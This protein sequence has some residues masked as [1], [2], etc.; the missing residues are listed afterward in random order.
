MSERGK[1]LLVVRTEQVLKPEI[2]EKLYQMMSDVAESLGCKA[3]VAD[4]GLDVSVHHDLRPLLQAQLEAQRETNELLTSLVE[5]LADDV[6]GDDEEVP[7]TYMDGTQVA[8]DPG[9]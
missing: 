4:G 1:S 9:G 3:V 7:L 6:A 2:R 5:A 8:L